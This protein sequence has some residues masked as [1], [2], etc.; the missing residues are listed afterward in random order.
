MPVDCPCRDRVQISIGVSSK[1][2]E[3]KRNFC[4]WVLGEAS[5]RGLKVSALE[6]GV[7]MKLLRE[8]VVLDANVVDGYKLD[9]RDQNDQ[10]DKACAPAAIPKQ[11]LLF[12]VVHCIT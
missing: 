3:F 9:A 8:R 10:E 7:I 11:K 2:R 1:R 4:G 6:E 5:K 12:F